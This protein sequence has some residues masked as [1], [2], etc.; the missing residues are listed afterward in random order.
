MNRLPA[1]AHR[2]SIGLVALLLIAVGAA[3]VAWR[4]DAEPVAGWVDRLD[5]RAAL[6]AAQ[7]SWWIWVLVGVTVLALGWGLLLLA[8]NIRPRAV[9]DALLDGSDQTGTLTV[10]PKL[11]ANAAAEELAGNPMFQKVTAKAIDDRSRSIIRLEVSAAP[12][13]SF[14]EVTAPVADTVTAIRTALG[15]SG[16]HVQAFVHL[17]R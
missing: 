15:D 14:D 5:E 3:A 7:A 16:V 10:A 2:L 11:M 4:V 13:R 12:N 9:D 17:D 8:T 6:D 1:T